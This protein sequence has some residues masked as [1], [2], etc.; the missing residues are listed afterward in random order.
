MRFNNHKSLSY[1]Y[2]FFSS[3]SFRLIGTIDD[4][5]ILHQYYNYDC[6]KSLKRYKLQN[7]YQLNDLKKI[8]FVTKDKFVNLN[9]IEENFLIN[10][11]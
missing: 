10:D 9:F 4:L 6:K 1:F 7:L 3:D 2:I 11:K 5:N 8:D